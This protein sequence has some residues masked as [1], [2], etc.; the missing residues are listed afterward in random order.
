MSLLNTF[1]NRP[2]SEIVSYAK[3][4]KIYMEN[5]SYKDFSCGFTGHSVIGWGNSEIAEKAK[6]QLLKIG[7]IDYK[8]FQDPNRI[9]IGDLFHQYQNQD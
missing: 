3:G 7:H 5:G 4:N 1:L 6:E 8:S 2:P 9:K